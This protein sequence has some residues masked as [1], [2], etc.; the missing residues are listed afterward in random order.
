MAVGGVLERITLHPSADG[1]RVHILWG[2]DATGFRS[3]LLSAALD[4]RELEGLAPLVA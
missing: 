2:S 1:V 4:P 3:T